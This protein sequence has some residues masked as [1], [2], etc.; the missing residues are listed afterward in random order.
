MV[1]NP[2]I[3]GQDPSAWRAWHRQ[4]LLRALPESECSEEGA[5]FLGVGM[6]KWKDG[7][8]WWLMDD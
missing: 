3:L 2:S 8:G 5:A 4:G 7:N 6:V 1:V